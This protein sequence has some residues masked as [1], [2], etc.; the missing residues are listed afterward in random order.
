MA[1]VCCG[2]APCC[3]AARIIV[4]GDPKKLRAKALG[5]CWARALA[6]PPLVRIDC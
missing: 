1:L 6:E 5:G 4:G 2:I 3:G